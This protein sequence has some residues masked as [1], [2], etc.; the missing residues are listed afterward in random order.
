[1]DTRTTAARVLA[2]VL[3]KDKTLD[4]AFTDVIPA[5]VDRKDKAYIKELCYG[6]LRWYYRLNFILDRYTDKPIRQKDTD[7]RAAILCGMYQLSYMR[8]PAHAAVSASVETAGQLSKGWAKQLINAVLRRYQREAAELDSLLHESESATYAHP[9]WLISM[10]R[11]D[12]PDYWQTIL[13]A[14]NQRP[15]MY[16]RVNL[17]K[18]R[19]DDYLQKLADI[20]LAANAV[21]GTQA[22]VRLHEPVD[23][24]VLPGF[25]QGLASVQDIAA[26]YAAMLLDLK[27][28]QRV[29]DACAAPGGKTA[30]IHETEPGL[31][32]ITAVEKDDKRLARLRD[33]C[34][35]L[36]VN[37][38]IIHADAT[39]YRDWWNGVPYDR[40]LLD[41]PCSATGVIRR[42]PDIKVLRREEEIGKYSDQQHKLLQA[43]WSM[44][45]TQGKLVYATCSILAVENDKQI[46]NFL[47]KFPDARNMDIMADW[48]VNT[49]FGIQTLPGVGNLAGD[50]FYYAVLVKH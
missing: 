27:A 32:Q 18:I 22:C 34:Q 14:N 20:K 38:E 12:W 26:Q 24:E 4:T 39:E 5:S 1:M 6:V 33:T 40:I 29:L 9:Q 37:A 46:E 15:P 35:R 28:G 10:I 45:N 42:H 8:T 25:A 13:A 48:G 36:G 47:K 23:I 11:S 50:G 43:A 17:Q 44:L 31:S 19:R 7:I 21:A 3:R 16:L 41:V 49:A 2:L 30:H